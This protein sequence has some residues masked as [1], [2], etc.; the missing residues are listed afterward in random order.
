MRDHAPVLQVAR[1]LADVGD[2]FSPSRFRSYI[3]EIKAL[4]P[5]GEYR[6]LRE[7]Y[8]HLV[9]VRATVRRVTRRLA[10]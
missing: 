9:Q 6:R 2:E 1:Y 3:A 4:V 8:R 7:A 10:R 5:P